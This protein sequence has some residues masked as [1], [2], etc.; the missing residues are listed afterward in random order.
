MSTFEKLRNRKT[1]L[2][3]ILALIVVTLG[4]A[5]TPIAA[6]EL[7]K[8]K[9][10]V[11]TTASTAP[12]IV[13]ARKGIFKKYGFD[14]EVVP[15][16]TGVQASQ[17][18]ASSQADWSG[19]GIEST[20]VAW[21]TEL[22]YQAYAMYAKGGDAYGI[23]VRK[24]SGIKK[25][26]D[27]KG[28]R[29]AVTNGTALAQALSQVLLSVGLPGNAALRVNATLSNMGQMMVAGSVDAMVGIEPFLTLAQ[30]Q[31]GSNGVLLA[32]MGKYV[33]GGGFFAI[34]N[35]WADANRDKIPKAV[36]ALWESE[37]FI[38]HNQQEAAAIVAEFTKTEPRVINIAFSHYDFNPLIDKFTQESIVKTADFLVK[39]GLL[40]VPVNPARHLENALRIEKALT[41]SRL[42]LLN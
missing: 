30:E 12:L 24:D 11:I 25:F 41:A 14:V 36:E 18:L 4:C 39:E 8:V 10:A 1:R 32:R 35:K 37:H 9:C 20:V 16:G 3:Q 29:V 33:Q 6:Q 38:R 2:L 42:D 19:S 21:G 22:P 28:K 7:T 31:M 27:L 17:A 34:S 26:E 5:L 15:V 40:P 23:L 13:G